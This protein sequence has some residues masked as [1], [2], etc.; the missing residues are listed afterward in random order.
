VIAGRSL[1]V[2]GSDRIRGLGR[3]IEVE[4]ITGSGTG[5][6]VYVVDGL[7][8]DIGNMRLSEVESVTILKDVNSAILYGTYGVNGV[9]L[10]T[11]KRGEAFKKRS[12][13]SINYGISTPRELPKY[14][15]SAD[16]M[17]Y[18]NQAR[19]NDGLGAQYSDETIENYRS[20]N[21][22]RYPDVDYYSDQYLRSFKNYYDL[23]GEF[24]GGN[25]VAKY[26]A[27]VGWNTAGSL[28]NFGE[29][30]EGRNNR[31]NV[32]GN[33]D[34]KVNDWIN[35]A[36]DVAGVFTNDKGPRGNYWS[37]AA[38]MRPNE[39]A[40]LL[41][42]NLISPDNTLLI[43]RKNDVNG[44]YLLGGVSNRT[45]TPF[46]TGYAGGS[47]ERVSRNFAFNNRVNVK[48]DKIT[49]G[50]SFHTNVSFDYFVTYDQTINNGYSVYEPIWSPTADSIIDLKQYGKDSRPGTQVVGNSSYR[51]RFGAYGMLG[52]DRTFNQRHR[53]TGSLLGFLGNYKVQGDFQGI[54]LAHTGFRAGYAYDRRFLVDFSGAYVS[55]VKLAEGNRGGISPSLGLGWVIS[56]ED[57]MSSSKNVNYLNCAQ[58]QVS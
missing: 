19:V 9:V 30:A 12:D 40:P 35:T 7:P 23:N 54:K 39:Y 8:R 33:V 6:L 11:T 29:G 44:Q 52:C 2:I 41:P 13:F 36:V 28:L 53:F 20:G 34:L 50:L 45:T 1:G 26:Y 49:P 21:K 22:Y 25:N 37:D 48:L 27:N 42:M 24:S 14:L 57:F 38:S 55:S 56:E 43:G 5:R 3:G 16:Y 46:G 15:N 10:I 31:F 51:R 18:F 58:P 47:N 32:R 4:D 17:T